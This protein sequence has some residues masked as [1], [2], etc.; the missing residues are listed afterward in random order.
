M[1]YLNR[2]LYKNFL[3]ILLVLLFFPIT[4]HAMQE[5]DTAIVL[6]AGPL[7]GVSPTYQIV[8][9]KVISG[10]YKGKIFTI[11]NETVGNY[12]Y[13]IVL[14]KGDKVSVY[15][16]EQNGHIDV[17]ILDY[18]RENYILYLTVFFLVLLILVG[19]AKGVKAILTLI[20]T[21]FVVIKILLPAILL[22]YNAIFVT[23]VLS[24][25]IILFSMFTIAGINNKSISAV[26]GT[27][28]GVLLAG[29][30]AY[31]I[32]NKMGLTGFSSDEI[33][34]LMMNIPQQ[35]DF[36]NLLFPGIVLGALGAIMDVSIS[37]ASAVDELSQVNKN[38]TVKELFSAGMN[39]GRDIIGTMVNTL[40]LAY[41]GSAIAMF[42]LF[43]MYQSS[44]NEI[45]NLDIVANEIIRSLAES[46]G[47]IISVPL[48]AL[49]ASILIKKDK[50]N[51]N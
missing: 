1:T 24:T 20:F 41:A 13:D 27:I 43:V 5:T 16:R 9:L 26:I 51:S 45:I 2:F 50:L 4:V 34:E 37:I 3:F 14:K 32:E 38:L 28:G 31:F 21:I 36:K 18:I 12:A 40:I 6:K 49:V 29:F 47:L 7:E 11:K 39:I 19:R 33:A 48:T 25:I 35:I 46:S 17:F 23:I 30:I 22:G 10:K 8:T 42:F 15:I 44:L